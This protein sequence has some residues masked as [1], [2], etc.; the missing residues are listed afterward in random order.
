MAATS[1]MYNTDALDGRVNVPNKASDYL[2]TV[3]LRKYTC[4][5]IVMAFVVVYS[6]Q[7]RVSL[8]GN[9]I[10]NRNIYLVQTRTLALVRVEVR[11]PQIT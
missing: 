2:N 3:L 8:A 11:A 1:W 6:M 5:T 7:S 9:K 10:P 4:S